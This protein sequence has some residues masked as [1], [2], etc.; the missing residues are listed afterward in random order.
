MFRISSASRVAVRVS[1]VPRKCRQLR[2]LLRR[3][4]ARHPVEHQRSDAAPGGIGV[5]RLRRRGFKLLVACVRIEQVLEPRTTCLGF[6][7]ALNPFRQHLSINL[8]DGRRLGRSQAQGGDESGGAPPI[9]RV[10]L[11]RHACNQHQR[12]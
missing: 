1:P 12:Q 4:H 7:S 11:R 10:D 9:G 6:A 2:P 5:G 8:L 3:E